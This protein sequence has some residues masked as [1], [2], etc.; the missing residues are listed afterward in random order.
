[1]RMDDY[2]SLEG[3]LLSNFRKYKMPLILPSF[4]TYI[5]NWGGKPSFLCFDTFQ[6]NDCFVFKMN[7]GIPFY[8]RYW[9]N[10]GGTFKGSEDEM[11]R[12][13]GHPHGDFEGGDVLWNQISQKF[14]LSQT[15]FHDGAKA[16]YIWQPS[17]QTFFGFE[18]PESIS[19][20]VCWLNIFVENK[21][22]ALIFDEISATIRT[23]RSDDLAH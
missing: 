8:G 4:T 16:P 13:A 17:T 11:W 23:R 7:L 3:K 6:R 2:L 18:N 5:G 21:I 10:V 20:K 22:N 1:M 12:E 15:R 19:Y 14:D 9:L